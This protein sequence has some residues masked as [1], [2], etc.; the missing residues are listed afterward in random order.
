[1]RR[2]AGVSNLSQPF[3][4]CPCCSNH[5][6]CLT[7][8]SDDALLFSAAVRGVQTAAT[9]LEVTPPFC[10]VI[11]LRSP[12][13]LSTP[14]P[15]PVVLSSCSSNLQGESHFGKYYDSP[16]FD[17]QLAPSL[18]LLLIS[19][20]LFP[21]LYLCRFSSRSLRCN[22]HSP[23]EQSVKSPR[24]RPE[25]DG[26]G[27]GFSLEGYM[28]VALQLLSDQVRKLYQDFQFFVFGWVR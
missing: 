25:P 11:F 16:C 26:E 7:N 17:N 1:M 22:V 4:L 21:P 5:L 24:N 15:A 23:R 10:P 3:S 18:V 6:F 28:P 14:R 20:A 13:S 12:L 27:E 2:C 8:G 9:S 19:H